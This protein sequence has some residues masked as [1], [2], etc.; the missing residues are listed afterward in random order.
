MRRGILTR[1]LEAVLDFIYHGETN[2]FQADLERFLAI[3]EELQLKGL[4][5]LNEGLS[6]IDVGLFSA[7]EGLFG[8]HERLSGMNE[9]LLGK[10]EGNP[11]INEEIALDTSESAHDCKAERKPITLHTE[12]FEMNTVDV[13]PLAKMSKDFKSKTASSLTEET[14]QTVEK[15]YENQNGF[16][17][18]LHCAYTSK[19]RGHLREH[20]E[21]HIEGLEYSCQ[22]CGKI[23]RSSHTFRDHLRKK[24]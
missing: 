7:N 20:V 15:L 17:A 11:D 24:H 16:W 14:A 21:K 6:G 4:S 2:I 8:N 19:Q 22:H 5:H 1:D 18:C 9:G 23:F 12:N 13:K 3:A 10:N